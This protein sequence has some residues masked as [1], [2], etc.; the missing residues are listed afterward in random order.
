[1]SVLTGDGG[2]LEGWRELGVSPRR[3]A[4]STAKLG[5]GG[6]SIEEILNC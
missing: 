4:K 1:V 2:A 6:V 3:T 5:D